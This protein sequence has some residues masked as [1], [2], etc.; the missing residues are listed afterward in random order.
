MDN[1]DWKWKDTGGEDFEQLEPGSYA[2]TCYSIIDLGTRQGEYM[3]VKNERHECLIGFEVDELMTIGDFAGKPFR[4]NRFYT[5][6]LGKKAN[7]RK[8]LENWRGRQFT[9][10]ELGGFD[11]KNIIGKPCLLSII[12]TD[13]GKTK[14]ASISKLPKNMVAPTLVN[15][16]VYFNMQT[17]ELNRPVFDALSEGIKKMIIQSPEYQSLVTRKPAPAGSSAPAGTGTIEDLDDIP[18]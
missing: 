3:G 1:E 4:V 16:T 17:R 8:D 12:R 5:V 13:K 6:S 15:P 18:F 7:L 14:I 2:G 10:E 9:D 11:P